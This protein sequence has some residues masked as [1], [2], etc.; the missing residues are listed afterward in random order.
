MLFF[1]FSVLLLKNL[2]VVFFFLFLSF[3]ATSFLLQNEYLQ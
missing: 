1:V 3:V 2:S